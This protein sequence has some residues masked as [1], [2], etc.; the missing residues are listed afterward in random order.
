MQSALKGKRLCENCGM[1]K[2]KDT[3]H[4]D[5]TIYEIELYP[6]KFSWRKNNMKLKELHDILS[7]KY[8]ELEEF[9]KN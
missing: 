4:D 3:G 9:N 5:S 2:I 7:E 6:P 1:K 8:L